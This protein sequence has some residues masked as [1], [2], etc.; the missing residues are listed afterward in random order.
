MNDSSRHR[1]CIPASGKVSIS[2]AC[3]WFEPKTYSKEEEEAAER[4][5]QMHVS[6]CL[7]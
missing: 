5:R 3:N 2:A 6:S 4:V 7:V 1:I